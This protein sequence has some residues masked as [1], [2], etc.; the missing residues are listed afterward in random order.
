[1]INTLQFT[2]SAWVQSYAL[3]ADVNENNL[4]SDVLLKKVFLPVWNSPNGKQIY[5]TLERTFRHIIP[6]ERF[7][8]FFSTNNHVQPYLE[9]VEIHKVKET[10]FEPLQCNTGLITMIVWLKIPHPQSI[11]F[12]YNDSEGITQHSIDV[13]EGSV[14]IFPSSLN[15]I[16]YPFYES[17]ERVSVH[18]TI[19][20]KQD[21]NWNIFQSLASV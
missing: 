1:M 14:M 7:D 18:C 11:T 3:E 9:N 6:A 15:H 12:V 2:S 21:D 5:N 10:Y 19:N 16:I 4:D 8:K 17:G 20:W 13:E